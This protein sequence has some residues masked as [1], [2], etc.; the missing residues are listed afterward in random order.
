[1]Q[2]FHRRSSLLI[3]LFLALGAGP[4]LA[5]P[6]PG[7]R[8]IQIPTTGSYFWRYVPA[9]LDTSRPAPA[10]IFLHGAGG[11]PEPYRNHVVAAA[12]RAGCV[13]VAPKSSSNLGWG[14]GADAET[15]GESLRLVREEMSIDA[16]RVGIAGHSAGGAYAYLLAYGEVSRYSAVFTL[17]ASSYPV[18]AVADPAYKA[19]IR[20]YYGTQDPNYQNGAYASLR[21]QWE[22]L[23]VSWEEDVRPGFGHSSWPGAAMEEGFLFLVSRAYPA[24]PGSGNA[25]VPGP[26]RLCLKDGRF[27]VEVTW[28]DFQNREGS[29]SVVPC[30][31]SDSGLFW[32][33]DPANW[34][35]LVKIV[36]GCALNG[37][38]WVFAAATTNV[39]YTL[40]V[41]DTST[42]QT[43]RYDNP[44]GRSAPATTDTQA[45][46]SCP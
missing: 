7:W 8:E 32:F 40:T 46:A 45:F 37:R 35:M 28:K 5:A 42:G 4:L 20:M 38:Y 43:A 26:G 2:P 16:S 24:D 36:D 15:V 13:V 31:T 22:R 44:L 17:A 6:A 9:S 23:G 11:R 39:Q 19:P 10:V 41:T 25:C 33:F 34:E 14:L 30:A 27:Q 29:G 1:M 3:L 18:G 12:E 21:Q